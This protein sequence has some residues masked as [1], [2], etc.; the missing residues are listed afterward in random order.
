MIDGFRAIWRG[1]RHLNQAGYLL[2]WC[3]VAWLLLT[4]PVITAPAAWAGMSRLAWTLQRAPTASFDDF[5]TGF[6]ENLVRGIPIAIANAIYW[7]VFFLNWTAYA[8]AQGL[9]FDLLRGVWL[10]TALLVIAVQ[11]YVGPL[12]YAMLRPSL[13]GAFR[14]AFVMILIN[15]LFTLTL[16]IG[17]AIVAV[18]STLIPIAWLLLTGGTLAAISTAAVIDRLRAAGILEA[19]DPASYM[20]DPS[21]DDV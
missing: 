12:Y 8:P 4:L 19:E 5:W 9:I 15:P 18:L 1:L 7:I 17:A 14:N 11:L 10:L 20:V 2:I 16:L 6:K 13:R 3:N 21:F